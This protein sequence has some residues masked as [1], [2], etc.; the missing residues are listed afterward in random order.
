MQ[1]PVG[2][3][4]KWGRHAQIVNCITAYGIL[5]TERH[6]CLVAASVY[7]KVIRGSILDSCLVLESLAVLEL[8][9]KEPLS[10]EP[11]VMFVPTKVIWHVGVVHA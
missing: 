11:L 6:Y 8:L 9:S 7:S 1:K 10:Q 4:V 3:S 2:W 5:S